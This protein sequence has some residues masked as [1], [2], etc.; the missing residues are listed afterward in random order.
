MMEITLNGAPRILT[1]ASLM[2]LLAGQEIDA[3]KRGI[4][5]A[6]ND[7]IVPR[8]AWPTITLKRGDVVEIVRPHSG[9]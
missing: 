9:G 5:V 1:G 6:V 4:A 3:S 2:A 8:A 7:E